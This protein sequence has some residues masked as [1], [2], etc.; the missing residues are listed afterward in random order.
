[1][2]RLDSH[3]IGIQQGETVLF[4]D[5][6]VGGEMWTGTGDRIVR[7]RVVFNEAFRDAPNVMTHLSMW[8]VDK[9][10]NNRMDVRAEDIDET[11]FDIL[12]QTWGDTR[13][14]RVRVGWMAIGTLKEADDWELY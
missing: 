2:K 8:D 10:T 13:V 7:R 5:F 6:Q 9:G 11:G 14:A 3:S 12:F 4:S 1:M